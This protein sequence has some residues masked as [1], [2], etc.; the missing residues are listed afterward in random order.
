M[1]RLPRAANPRPTRIQQGC[2]TTANPQKEF[3]IVSKPQVL[4]AGESWVSTGMHVKG[5]ND[6]STAFYEVGHE[7]LAAAL[8][9]EF[10]V[11]FLPSH[12]AATAFPG[13]A[14]ELRRY[15]AVL[16]SDM[17]ADTLLLHPDTFIRMRPT[18]NRLIAVQE[19]VAA[20]GGFGMIGGYMSFGGFGGRARYHR[21]EIEEILPVTCLPYDDRVET[22]QGFHPEPPAP[23]DQLTPA[24]HP[25]LAGVRGPWPMLLGYNRIA[26]KPAAQVLL[27]RGPG[28]DSDPILAVGAYGNGRTLAFASDCAPHWGSPDFVN[29]EHYATFW[30]S[31]VR[32]LAG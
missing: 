18:P 31:A 16:F 19:Y 2:A 1:L 12:E 6:F 24:D 25:V 26:A 13:S 15:A 29:W 28:L 14:A 10:D 32:W 20:G 3:P 23:T 22:P 8:G 9:A 30:R 5:F 17:G 7:A 27:H 21:T 11:V 4:L